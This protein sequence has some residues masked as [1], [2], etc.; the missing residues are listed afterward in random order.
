MCLKGQPSCL[1]QSGGEG[2]W[3]KGLYSLGIG[4]PQLFR[5]RDETPDPMPGA[6]SNPLHSV[7]DDSKQNSIEDHSSGVDNGQSGQTAV[8]WISG[9]DAAL[10]E[11]LDDNTASEGLR[12]ALNAFPA[13][14]LPQSF[15]VSTC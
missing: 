9:H 14:D 2:L 5:E 15:E 8:C 13:V 10:L 7:C 6:P 1:L 11:Q 12:A 3:Y 4:G